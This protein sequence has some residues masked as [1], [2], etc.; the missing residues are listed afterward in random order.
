MEKNH[1]KCQFSSIIIHI[2]VY[3]NAKSEKGNFKHLNIAVDS[4]F[5]FGRFS[6]FLVGH[7]K[8]RFISSVH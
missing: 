5:S 1:I 2:A 7:L 3:T 8:F 4:I 6:L